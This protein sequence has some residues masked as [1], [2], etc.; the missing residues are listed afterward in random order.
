MGGKQNND[1]KGT[2]KRENIRTQG[3]EGKENK[4]ARKERKSRKQWEEKSERKTLK[5]GG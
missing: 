2:R 5:N 3:G 1:Q 4:R